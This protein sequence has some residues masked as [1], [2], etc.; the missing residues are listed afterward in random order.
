[1]AMLAALR[2]VLV[3]V[4]EAAVQCRLHA[5]KTYSAILGHAHG[6]QVA[7]PHIISIMHPI[8]A[9]REACS[10]VSKCQSAVHS[11]L[12]CELSQTHLWLFSDCAGRGW[13]E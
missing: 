5:N 13:A 10:N 2:D 4:S 9:Q 3:N 11:L 7:L 6:N 1:M 12:S 8:A